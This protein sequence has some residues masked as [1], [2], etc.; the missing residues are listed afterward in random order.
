MLNDKQGGQRFCDE[1]SRLLLSVWPW[2]LGHPRSNLT[3]PLL[4]PTSPL[5]V[6]KIESKHCGLWPLT[7][8]G[9]PKWSQ[10]ALCVTSIGS[11]IVTL[12]VLNYIFYIKNCDFGFWFPEVI[13][14]QIWW[15][16]SK[17][18]RHFSIWPL[19]SK[20]NAISLTVWSQITR[21]TTH[22]PNQ[23]PNQ[24]HSYNVC[25]NTSSMQYYVLQPGNYKRN[26]KKLKPR[27]QMC[28]AVD[29]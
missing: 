2:F 26:D 4:S 1:R 28:H 3:V 14:G 18:H 29:K 25:R 7:S 27:L 17:A 19:L 23:P 8:R 15:C 10:W 20:S 21:V 16:Q 24:K 12:A 13:Q 6:F 5:T 22:P 9:H 11:N